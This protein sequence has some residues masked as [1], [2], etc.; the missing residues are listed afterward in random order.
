MRLAERPEKIARDKTYAPMVR[1]DYALQ[2]LEIMRNSLYNM[3][4]EM[5]GQQAKTEAL[6]DRENI[7]G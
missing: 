4:V 3:F 2:A 5:D 7:Y 6:G 1:L